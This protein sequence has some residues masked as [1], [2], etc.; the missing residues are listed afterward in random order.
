ML[1]P[2]V[3]VW[4]I[5]VKKW[6]CNASINGSWLSPEALSTE[7]QEMFGKLICHH[8]LPYFETD[9]KVDLERC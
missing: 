9:R 5:C 7:S 4:L 1:L 6:S 2:R 3:G 8:K